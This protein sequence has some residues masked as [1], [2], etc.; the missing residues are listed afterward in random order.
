MFSSCFKGYK[1]RNGQPIVTKLVEREEDAH[2]NIQLSGTG[3]LGDLLA[4]LVK[5]KLNIQRVRA[6]TFGYL[7]RSL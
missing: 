2:G 7:Q 3:A 5:D 1:M 4:R 6:D